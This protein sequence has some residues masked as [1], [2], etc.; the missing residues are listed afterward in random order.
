MPSIRESR[1]KKGLTQ[2]QLAT[3]MKVTV[4]QVSA[5]ER[6]V[7][8]PRLVN[9]KKL[10]S[11]L[12]LSIDNLDFPMSQEDVDIL[13]TIKRDQSHEAINVVNSMISV[14]G[15]SQDESH[16]DLDIVRTNSDKTPT[17][18]RIK[19]TNPSYEDTWNV[20]FV[21]PYRIDHEES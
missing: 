7:T 13:I 8:Q 21:D 10:C 6:G 19:F 18:R 15:V 16:K 11:I 9:V 1:I 5:W 2:L 12:H 20:R 17:H 14:V 3:I 4:H